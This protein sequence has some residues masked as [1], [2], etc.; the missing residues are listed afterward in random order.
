[1]LTPT[2][3]Q[4]NAFTGLEYA[5]MLS[6]LKNETPF[7]I[8]PFYVLKTSILNKTTS[9][10]QCVTET[11]VIPVSIYS[12]KN[13]YFL[14]FLLKRNLQNNIVPKPDKMNE[15]YYNLTV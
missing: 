9:P 5:I 10:G 12:L 4:V 6:F 15:H 13:E 11:V 8:K 3:S 14:N 2:N 1:M 7:L